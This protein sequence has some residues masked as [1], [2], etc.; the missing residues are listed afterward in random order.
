MIIP[1]LITA[2]I[3]TALYASR[4]RVSTVP[5]TELLQGR[6]YRIGVNYNANLAPLAQG[7]LRS[8]LETI[9]QA[10]LVEGL[11]ELGFMNVSFVRGPE[12]P[13]NGIYTFWYE[14]TW[15]RRERTLGGPGSAGSLHPW[16]NL[17]FYE[18]R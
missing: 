12:G 10:M 5:A 13:T 18:I 7:D 15:A 14:G 11:P 9:R 6:R 3:F 17:G 16:F 2:A 8:Q 4:E 1:A